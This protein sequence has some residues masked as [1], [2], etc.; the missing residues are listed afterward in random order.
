MTADMYT[1]LKREGKLYGTITRARLLQSRRNALSLLLSRIGA[2]PWKSPLYILPLGVAYS[3]VVATTCY[4][5]NRRIS[6]WRDPQASRDRHIRKPTIVSTNDGRYSGRNNYASRN[7]YPTVRSC[8]K[9]TL[10]RLLWFIGEGSGIIR[11]PRGWQ[12]GVCGY[13]GPYVV[14]TRRQYNPEWRMYLTAD[15]ILQGT[16][17]SEFA[18]CEAAL[19]RQFWSDIRARVKERESYN[20]Q[21]REYHRIWRTEVSVSVKVYLE[22]SVCQIMLKRPGIVQGVYPS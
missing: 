16:P 21:T 12:F 22:G 18:R 17:P 20:R 7:H 13:L 11:A 9:I 6:R 3:T 1:R 10:K 14:Q 15:A 5:L 2:S 19:V 4:N 8:V